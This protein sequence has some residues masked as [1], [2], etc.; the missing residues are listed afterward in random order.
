SGDAPLPPV[1]AQQRPL[2]ETSGT[3]TPPLSRT[4]ATSKAAAVPRR[5]A[6]IPD[7]KLIP[8]MQRKAVRLVGL[9]AAALA[10]LL[11]GYSVFSVSP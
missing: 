8:L 9:A 7:G 2:A 6:N 1:P 3:G 11:G 5:T 4:S 10:L